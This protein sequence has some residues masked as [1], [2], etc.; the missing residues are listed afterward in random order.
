MNIHRIVKFLELTKPFKIQITSKPNDNATAKYW[1]LYENGGKGN[2]HSHR[3]MVYA[4]NQ[5][6]KGERSIE[7]LIV[8]E[9]IHAWQ[10]EYGFE[11][12]HGDS[13]QEMAARVS[14]KFDIPELYLPGIDI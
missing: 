12:I 1:G 6:V 4:G 2:L 10:E 3:I 9:L 8:H 7:T 14:K 5:K 11:D 13:F